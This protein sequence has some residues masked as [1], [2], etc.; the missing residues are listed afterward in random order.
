MMYCDVKEQEYDAGVVKK[1]LKILSCDFI[2]RTLQ[3]LLSVFVSRIVDS[4]LFNS[5]R[6]F[7]AHRVY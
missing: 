1:S 5:V 2:V 7:G 4:L 6:C 3:V